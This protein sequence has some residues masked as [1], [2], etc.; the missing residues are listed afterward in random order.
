MLSAITNAAAISG[1]SLSDYS[2]QIGNIASGNDQSGSSKYKGVSATVITVVLNGT[3]DGI[4]K[5]ISTLEESV[6]ISEITNINGSG[7]NVSITLQFY[8][9]PF[10]AVAFSG[11]TAIQPLS[12][13]NVA[14]LQKLSQWENIPQLQTTQTSSGSGT[15]VPLF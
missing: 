12:A 8:Q 7:E 9:K 14:L 10:P 11:E 15:S 6:P 3:I 5:F 2:F 13:A 1:V 4:R